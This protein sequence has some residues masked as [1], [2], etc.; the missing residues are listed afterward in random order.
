MKWRRRRRKKNNEEDV[1]VW[2]KFMKS[3]REGIEVNF[4]EVVGFL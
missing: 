2:P 4:N 1:C 3:V